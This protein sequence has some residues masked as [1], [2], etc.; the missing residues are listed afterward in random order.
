MKTRIVISILFAVIA[1]QGMAQS[2]RSREFQAR[3]GYGMGAY[4]TKSELTIRDQNTTFSSSDT[5]GAVTQHLNFDLRYEL[6]ERFALG[7]DMKFG[8]YLYDPED[9]NTGK[10]NVYRVTGLKGEFNISKR[11]NF[12]WFVG[13]GLHASRLVISEETTA[14]GITNKEEFDYRGIGL[15][16]NSGIIKYFGDGPI[17]MFFT[18]GYD[19]HSFILDEYTINGQAVDFD[20]IDVTLDARGIDLSLGLIVRIRP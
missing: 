4:G 2:D 18:M 9:D 13:A 7:V 15:S 5:S 8:A 19:G 3:I 14:L 20:E 1:F 17:G 6:S 16:A 11:P 12:R 10:S